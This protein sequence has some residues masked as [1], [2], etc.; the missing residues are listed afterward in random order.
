ME[1]TIT[2]NLNFASVEVELS[3]VGSCIQVRK[4]T[5][6]DSQLETNRRTAHKYMVKVSNCLQY[7][8]IL[9]PLQKEILRFQK[10]SDTHHLHKEGCAIFSKVLTF[11]SSFRV[12][13]TKN[14]VPLHTGI[15]R[16]SDIFVTLANHYKICIYLSHW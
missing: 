6:Q 15:K 4:R 9:N 14:I 12:D 16:D 10:K 8:N 11:L 13:S 2:V 1:T 3:V 5:K 7:G